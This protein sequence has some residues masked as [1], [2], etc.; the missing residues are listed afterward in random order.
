MNR[1]IRAERKKLRLCAEIAGEAPRIERE[2]ERV[3]DEKS[4]QAVRKAEQERF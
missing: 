2:L 1:A 3:E 4:K